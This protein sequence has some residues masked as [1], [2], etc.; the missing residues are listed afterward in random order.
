MSFGAR[1][2]SPR[3][4]IAERVRAV[5]ICLLAVAF[6]AA[7]LR[8]QTTPCA[9]VTATEIQALLGAGIPAGTGNQRSCRWGEVLKGHAL[10]V[11]T[12]ANLPPQA[13]AGMREG[14][15]RDGKSSM[16]E[17]TIG[18]GAA[19]VLTSFGVVV[20]APK[21]GRV[22]QLQ[23]HVG[24]AGSAADRDAVRALS[25]TVVARF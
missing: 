13:M 6:T 5:V 3:R 10:I 19:S 12:Y 4:R 14:M 16:D 21:A 25:K 18:A 9:L 17:P 7:P 1:D 20:I 2:E 22:V 11:L 8:G 15:A 23:Y 24:H